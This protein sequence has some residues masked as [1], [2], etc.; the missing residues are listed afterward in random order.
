MSA[1]PTMSASHA[2]PSRWRAVVARDAAADGAFVYAVETTGV[3][4]RPSCA[5][6]T[7]RPENVRFYPDPAAAEAAGFRACKRCRP[8]QPSAA[9]VRAAVVADLCRFI[10]ESPEAPTVA[11]LAARAG[12]SP[13]HLSRVFRAVT[14]LTPKRY[15]TGRRAERVRD[16]LGGEASIT[17][18]MYDAGYNS[19]ARFYEDADGQLGMT[20][21]AWRR[22]GAGETIR[23]AVGATSLGAVLV[24]GTERGVCAVALGDDA[25]GLVRD[26]QDRFPRAELVGGAAAFEAWVAGVVGLVE[27]PGAAPDLPLDV[28][29]TAFQRR[30]WT[31]LR[32]I[33]PG[34]TA[35][36][37]DVARAIGAP[38]ASRAVAAACAANPVALAIPCHRVVRRDGALAGYR[39]GI[40][41]KRA[42]I[43][44]ERAARPSGRA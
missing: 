18:A 41:R 20:P 17:E 23:F 15:V 2:D 5:A 38:R 28:R 42:L 30:V 32:A 29:G 39:W 27:A 36:Y 40:E 26:L 25:D 11:E 1:S 21:G 33:P 43:D 22:G 19:S 37:A 12:W 31:A 9:E 35:T 34:T 7:P 44:R 10:D 16:A 13:S 8:G 14:G 3:Y 6:R 24:A 4:C